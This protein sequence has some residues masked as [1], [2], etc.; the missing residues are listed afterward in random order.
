MKHPRG[1]GD[2]PSHHWKPGERE[3]DSRAKTG[4]R[5]KGSFV[6]SGIWEE[7]PSLGEWGAP[8]PMKAVRDISRSVGVG[9]WNLFSVVMF[10]IK[11]RLRS[12][13]P[14]NRT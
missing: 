10:A 9:D 13:P 5:V 4:A 2:H 14:R 11:W 12:A 6:K 1:L 7:G 3:T 8:D